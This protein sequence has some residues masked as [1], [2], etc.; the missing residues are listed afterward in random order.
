MTEQDFSYFPAARLTDDAFRQLAHARQIQ[1]EEGAYCMEFRS[2]VQKA[3]AALNLLN[4]YYQFI[5]TVE[6]E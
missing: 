4:E 6:V 2:A 3:R 1:Q 5:D